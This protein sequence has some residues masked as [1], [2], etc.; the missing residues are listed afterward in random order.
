MKKG[1]TA[2]KSMPQ[3]RTAKKSGFKY[4]LWILPFLILAFLFSYFPL[5]GSMRFLITN[6]P[7][8]LQ[9]ANS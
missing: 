7:E 2:V 4:F 3:S 5:H 8:A 6:R 1:N 9:T